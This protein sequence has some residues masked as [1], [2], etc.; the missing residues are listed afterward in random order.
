MRRK[1]K[2]KRRQAVLSC[3]KRPDERPTRVNIFRRCR[4]TLL[5]VRQSRRHLSSATAARRTNGWHTCQYHT[6]IQ[7]LMIAIWWEIIMAV[8]L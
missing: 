1:T 6:I 4:N 3:Q 7:P 5:G 8:G 2:V